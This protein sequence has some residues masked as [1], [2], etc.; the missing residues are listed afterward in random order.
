MHNM[1]MRHQYI[2]FFQ[3][4]AGSAMILLGIVGEAL[5]F[6]WRLQ[7]GTRQSLLMQGVPLGI[8]VSASIKHIMQIAPNWIF[9]QFITNHSLSS[10]IRGSEDNNCHEALDS[11]ITSDHLNPA[12]WISLYWDH[13]PMVQRKVPIWNQSLGTNTEETNNRFEIDIYICRP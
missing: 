5:W 9:L 4:I 7:H 6:S 3:F 12:Y 11:L 13:V 8:L 2:I 1:K 10:R